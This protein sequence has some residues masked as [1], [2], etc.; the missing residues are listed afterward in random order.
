M[1]PGTRSKKEAPVP[2]QDPAVADTQ[3][4]KKVKKCGHDFTDNED[5]PGK[6]VK[7]ISI[8]LH[9][10]IVLLHRPDK[11]LSHNAHCPSIMDE[12]KTPSENVPR[13]QK[14]QKPKQQKRRR[15]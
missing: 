13:L 1:P 4:V 11:L 6:K 9:Y 3:P 7:S 8:I 12:M 5:V 14:L 10:L 15:K 2:F